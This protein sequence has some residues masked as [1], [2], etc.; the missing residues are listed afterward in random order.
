[1]LQ[2]CWMQEAGSSV[3]S[4]RTATTLPT[5]TTA[6]PSSLAAQNA[7]LRLSDSTSCF[8]LA[9]A[10]K[11]YELRILERA[12]SQIMEDGR[13]WHR[14]ASGGSRGGKTGPPGG[15]GQEGQTGVTSP[16]P[17]REANGSQPSAPV[18]SAPA[19]FSDWPPSF[20]LILSVFFKSS[21]PT[22]KLISFIFF[23]QVE[24]RESPTPPSS[25]FFFFFTVLS[26][27]S[28]TAFV[29]MFIWVDFRKINRCPDSL[30][31]PSC[32]SNPTQ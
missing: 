27:L 23:G 15:G 32:L 4:L 19:P 17:K 2:S 9:V 11:N 5:L 28:S 30:P 13:D 20:L 14:R 12:R 21:F 1:M 8:K 7:S 25:I 6:V 31:F 22:V 24:L 29:N 3:G 16:W 10:K 26:F 18:P